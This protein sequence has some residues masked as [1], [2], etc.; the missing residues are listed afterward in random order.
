[1]K[2]LNSLFLIFSLSAIA[3]DPLP[4]SRFEHLTGI[5]GSTDVKTEWDK[6]YNQNYFVFGK[7]PAKFLAENY[8]F[9]PTRA[10][11]LDLGMGEGRNSVFLAQ[12]DYA[13]TGIDI[14]SVAIKKAHQLAKEYKVKIKTLT[15][16][17]KSHPFEPNTWD[18][19]LCFYY[20]DRSLTE[21]IKTWL[22]PGGI[23]IY[24]AYTVKQ[25][26]LAQYKNEP[27]DHFLKEQELLK[28]FPGFKVLKFEEPN[29]E[30][31]HRTAIIL[32]KQHS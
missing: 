24:E 25:K 11:V 28:M 30:K 15:S 32:Q 1:M 12:K 2:L 14:S 26:T 13:V 27:D 7:A 5:K 10:S 23:L 6:R 9:L 17:V 8:H 29:S 4:A 22:K 16:S 31:E 3:R 21:K 20:V 19:I 18:A